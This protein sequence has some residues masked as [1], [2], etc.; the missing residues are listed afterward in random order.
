[1][2]ARLVTSD[3]RVPEPEVAVH[4]GRGQ[5][6]R[7]RGG[8]A[9]ADVVDLRELARLVDLPELGE[10]ANLALVVAPRPRER[11]ET[12]RRHVGRVD[13]HEGVDEVVSQR[14]AGRLAFEPG[15][16]LVRRHRPV[17]LVHDVERDADHR[18]VVAD[19]DDPREAREPCLAQRELK[20]RLADHV[21]RRGRKRR[22]RRAPEHEPA[23]L[24]LQEEGEVRAAPL[25]DPA[26][27]QS[28]RPEAALVEEPANAIEDQ[29]WRL[30]QAI[31]VS[32]GLDDV[33]RAILRSP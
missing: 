13:L 19:G 10:A 23:V 24:S 4:D 18:L 32:R 20:A 31:G 5:R 1:M 22:T 29:E 16:R 17:E 25:A 6:V 14:T 27:A 7:Q 12:R 3:H 21:V 33:H 26:S 9:F 8:E 30:R 15:R 28:S 2:R 11:D